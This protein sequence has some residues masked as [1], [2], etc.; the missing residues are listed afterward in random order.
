MLPLNGTEKL[1]PKTNVANRLC[2][3]VVTAICC[4]SATC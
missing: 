4:T 3:S 2:R 1:I